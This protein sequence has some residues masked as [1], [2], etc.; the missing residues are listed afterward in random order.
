MEPGRYL[1]RGRI[2][3]QFENLCD[4]SENGFASVVSLLSILFGQSACPLRK[5]SDSPGL[6]LISR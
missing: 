3:F 6:D 4:R 1:R 5:G 2:D